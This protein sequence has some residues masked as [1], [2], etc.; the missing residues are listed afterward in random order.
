MRQRPSLESLEGR[1]LL[2]ITLNF[3]NLSQNTVVGTSYDS[4]GADFSGATVITQAGS[5][6][7]NYLP[8]SGTN[9]VDNRTGPI[10]VSASA[11][12]SWSEVG[13]YI[14]GNKKIVMTAYQAN[15]TVVGTAS[16]SGANYIGSGTGLSPNMKLDIKGSKIAY[17]K[18][19]G[20]A[21]NVPD[22]TL[23]DF[24]FSSAATVEINNTPGTSDNITV[25]NPDTTGEH[26]VQ[27]I[28]AMITNNTTATQTFQLLVNPSTA[29]TL[30]QTS[31]TLAPGKSTNVTITPTADSTNPNDVKIVAKLNGVKVGDD[32]M[33]IAKVTFGPQQGTKS[34]DIKASDTP[35]GMPDRIPPR[36]N[37]GVYVNVVPDLTGSGESVTLAVLGQ[38]STHGVVT[39]NG[40]STPQIITSA[41]TVNLSSPNGTTQ[42]V[43]GNAGQLTFTV[44]AHGVNAVQSYGFSV[45]AMPIKFSESF[46]SDV[47]GNGQLG[48]SAKVVWDSDS[49]VIGDLNDVQFLEQ[50]I[51]DPGTGIFNP[52]G[53]VHQQPKPFAANTG[54]GYDQHSVDSI[55]ITLNAGGTR[56]IR[57][58]YT[59]S[60]ARTGGTFYALPNSGYLITHTVYQDILSHKWRLKTTK[61]GNLETV[62]NFTSIAGQVN[63]IISNTLP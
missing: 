55:A 49:G 28:P 51:T 17:V 53:N 35:A 61:V 42:T 56:T 25:Y 62:N 12:T 13:G 59:Y 3:E 38:S 45:A 30:S 60:D 40:Q 14:T 58:V 10:K 47:T 54:V 27:T 41:G 16:T 24:F 18:F 34:L 6:A 48:L 26:W 9:V 44:V 33:T 29:A 23:D 11:G 15:G 7:T 39:I 43:P 19:V 50:I 4:L 22:F 46:A 52:P 31:V 57:Q 63:G 20:S 32:Q 36:I 2:S 1:A 5:L 37:T 21:T 8:H